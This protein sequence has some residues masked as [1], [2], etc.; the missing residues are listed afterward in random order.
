MIIVGGWK[1]YKMKCSN[2]IHANVCANNDIMGQRAVNKTLKDCPDFEDKNLFLSLP[3]PIGA[4]VYTVYEEC[5]PEFGVCPF[6]GGYGTWRCSKGNE[7]C[8]PYIQ[9]VTFHAGL[10]DSVGKTLFVKKEDAEKK[11]ENLKRRKK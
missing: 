2:C 5:D 8:G 9:E 11:V 6:D 4:V 3:C 7:K 1:C 10:V